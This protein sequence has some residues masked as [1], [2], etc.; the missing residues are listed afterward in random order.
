[1]PAPAIESLLETHR[2]PLRLCIEV[3]DLVEQRQTILSAS[4]VNSWFT[5]SVN[6]IKWLLFYAVKFEGGRLLCNSN[7]WN[8]Y[9][10]CEI[11]CFSKKQSSIKTYQNGNY[12][13]SKCL[14]SFPFHFKQR[15]P[16]REFCLVNSISL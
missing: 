2:S 11:Y 8:S 12:L 13:I 16:N 14:L 1:M 5:E 4:F 7:N 15:W 10:T 3:P 9:K 6:P